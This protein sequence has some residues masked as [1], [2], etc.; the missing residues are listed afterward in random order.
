MARVPYFASVLPHVVR[1]EP[2][3]DGWSFN[4]EVTPVMGMATAAGRR[5]A[6]YSNTATY[7]QMRP[8]CYDPVARLADLD[9]MAADLDDTTPD[10]DDDTGSTGK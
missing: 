9:D 7:E 4:G 1:M 3:V 6:E 8:G 2:G 5:P 10:D